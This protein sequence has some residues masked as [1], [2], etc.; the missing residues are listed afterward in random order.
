M[1]PLSAS[2]RESSHALWL[3]LLLSFPF[4]DVNAHFVSQ[5][6]QGL[7]PQASCESPRVGTGT[8]TGIGG[9]AAGGIDGSGR[10][11]VGGAA[12]SGGG[13]NAT[14]APFVFGATTSGATATATATFGGSIGTGGFR[15]GGAEDRKEESK[16]GFNFGIT[17]GGFSFGKIDKS[18]AE[19]PKPSRFSF[20]NPKETKDDEPK[21]ES[22]KE[23]A[24]ETPACFS[25]GIKPPAKSEPPKFSFGVT[26]A[27]EPPKFSFGPTSAAA[28]FKSSFNATTAAEPPKFSFR[29][30]PVA[31]PATEG[32]QQ[33]G[34]IHFGV[35]PETGK[36]ATKKL[37]FPKPAETE[38]E[39]VSMAPSFS[40]V[41]SDSA[42]TNSME[43]PSN[44]PFHFVTG[45][46]V[47]GD[48][49]KYPFSFGGPTGAPSAPPA[50]TEAQ[51][52]A[53]FG[54]SASAPVSAKDDG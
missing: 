31:E 17:E 18:S 9:S 12:A 29:M 8:A 41:G 27:V 16:G 45:A 15:F 13:T 54:I 46:P 39:E 40:L 37:E 19:A 51:T 14:A 50:I 24:P 52:T 28:P 11:A 23:V 7:C 25:F 10:A 38:N 1:L 4:N 36:S 20:P 47:T 26:P 21:P 44:K 43:P 30:T 6:E 2:M 53:A 33:R 3:L 22:E 35:K 32:K 48:K 49:S 34:G 42:A 5:Q